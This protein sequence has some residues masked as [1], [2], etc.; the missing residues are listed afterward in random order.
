[1]SVLVENVPLG[2]F[3]SKE[4]EIGWIEEGSRLSPIVVSSIVR[5]QCKIFLT[6]DFVRKVFRAA[7]DFN[8]MDVNAIL[9]QKDDRDIKIEEELKAIQSESA[10]SV[11][12][13]EALTDH[14]TGFWQKSKWAKKL[15]K[16]VV[17]YDHNI[18]RA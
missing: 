18:D 10:L 12:A 5:D 8:I 7:L 2:S 11:A 4:S 6:E 3:S 1:M 14:S 13:K 9:T 15:S 17:R 16:K